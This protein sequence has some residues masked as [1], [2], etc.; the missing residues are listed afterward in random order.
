MD[1]PI[2]LFTQGK[3]DLATITK[4]LNGALEPTELLP[5]SML[6]DTYKGRRY[7]EMLLK[8]AIHIGDPKNIA[9][10]T[11]FVDFHDRVINALC[12]HYDDTR[13]IQD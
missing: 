13:L 3:Y 11:Q 10:A 4:L 2:E 8:A 7:A 6:I 5:Y 1:N 9:K 12:R